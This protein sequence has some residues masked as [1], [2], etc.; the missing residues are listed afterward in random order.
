[1]GGIG[2]M[3]EIG[4]VDGRNLIV[5]LIAPNQGDGRDDESDIIST[6]AMQDSVS[7]MNSDTYISRRNNG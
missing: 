2:G 6:T 4:D 5:G 3:G 1:M 7:S